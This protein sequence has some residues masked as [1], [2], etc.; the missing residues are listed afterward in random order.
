MAR[1]VA[2]VLAGMVLTTVGLAALGVRSE[3][4]SRDVQEVAAATGADP[5]DLAGAVN[6]LNH[7]GMAVDVWTYA[8]SERLLPPLEKTPPVAA[9]PAAPAS[10]VWS[11]LAQCESTSNWSARTG[12]GYFGGLQE[13][14]SFW[15]RY[16]GLAYAPR[17]DL[18][19]ASAQIA[20]AERGL[21]SQ[22]WGA[23]PNCSRRLGLR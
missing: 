11:R 10:G 8:R 18:A 4:T 23:W 13:D 5:Q 17:P 1:F 22:G 21:A 14:M 2:G 15:I 19:S 7:D 16:G 12:N 20:V 6:T 9:S 3:E